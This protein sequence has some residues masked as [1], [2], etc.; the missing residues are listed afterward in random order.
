MSKFDKQAL[1]NIARSW[2]DGWNKNDV[3]SFAALY[4]E[5]GEYMDPGF[6]ILRRGHD[7][8]KMHYGQWRRAAPDFRMTA[9]RII[10]GDGEA[11]VI[12]QAIGEGTYNGVSLGDGTM[13]ATGLPFRARLCAV[14]ALD[15]N[16]KITR[17]T[18]Y[19]D[20]AQMPNG[21]KPPL[22]DLDNI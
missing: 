22:R 18:E 16:G 19:Y 21:V 13:D 10:A 11:V 1:E 9:E 17:C 5:N 4:A 12:V 14:L 6:G 2:V 7:F 8:V 3:D 20:P 15:D